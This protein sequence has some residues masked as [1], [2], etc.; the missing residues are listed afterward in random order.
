MPSGS[1]AITNTNKN[2]YLKN[3]HFGGGLSEFVSSNDR[4]LDTTSPELWTSVGEY[5][6]TGR[7]G[8]SLIDG[9]IEGDGGSVS[10][11]EDDIQNV[12]ATS[13]PAIEALVLAHVWDRVPSFEDADV[14][15]A[16]RVAGFV[17][18]KME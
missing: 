3:I 6:Y 1:T 17:K 13:V 5:A 16:T 14:V 18:H 2:V 7:D 11:F 4:V 10:E 15:D 8:Q 12:N 9:V